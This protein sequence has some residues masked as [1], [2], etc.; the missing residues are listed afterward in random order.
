MVSIDDFGTGYSSLSY[1]S[2]LPVDILK[3][4]ISFV[5]KLHDEQNRKVV[6]SIL[7]LAESLG[8][9]VVAEGIE[10]P[11]QRAYFRERGC[12]G[13]QGHLFMSA[14]PIDELVSRFAALRTA[15]KRAALE[16]PSLA[17]E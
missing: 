12:Y 7:T 17:E 3:I 10:T 9:N 5:R 15:P 14:Q 16:E 11:E 4:D 6:N 1:L 8:I 13:M 2:R